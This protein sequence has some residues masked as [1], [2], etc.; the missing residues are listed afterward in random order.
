MKNET[1]LLRKNQSR[2]SACAGLLNEGGS[3]LNL[4]DCREKRIAQARKGNTIG[5]H[6]I[7]TGW[8]GDSPQ[9][10]FIEEVA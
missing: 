9:D 5:W 3:H 8:T 7:Q 6:L 10:F 4:T 1:P 2:C